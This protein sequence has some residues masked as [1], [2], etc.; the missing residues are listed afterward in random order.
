MP[1]AYVPSLV[2]LTA[3]LVLLAL[4]LVRVYREVRRFQGVQQRVVRDVGDRSGLLKARVAGLRVAFA[5]RRR[6]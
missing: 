1:Y 4:L 3:A 6:T 5:E 2:L